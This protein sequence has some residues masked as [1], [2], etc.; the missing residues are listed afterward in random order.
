MHCSY[1]N[2]G[3]TISSGNAKALNYTMDKRNVFWPIPYSSAI[4]ANPKGA[5]HQNYGYDGYDGNIEMWST[6]E[7]AVADEDNAG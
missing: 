6:W 2:R 5:L 4:E 1:Y 7:E 3:Y